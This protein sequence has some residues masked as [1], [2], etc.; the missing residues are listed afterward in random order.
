MSGTVPI[1]A[2][3]QDFKAG[4]RQALNCGELYTYTFWCFRLKNGL[5][6]KDSN[7]IYRMRI[8]CMRR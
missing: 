7:A 6:S 4:H 5:G 3:Q 8:A 1:K 2:Q